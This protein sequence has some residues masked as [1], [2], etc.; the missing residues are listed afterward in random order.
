MEVGLVLP[1]AGSA[2]SAD[3]IAQVATHAERIGLGSVW[4]FERQ[5]NPTGGVQVSGQTMQ[6]P[7]YDTVYSPLEVLAFVAAR[8]SR[9]R[10]GTS[11]MVAL[12]HNPVALARSLATLDR[13]SNGRVVA[14]LGQG[15]MREEFE[16]AGVPMGRQGAGFAEFIDALRAVWGP[17]LVSFA[18]RF[19]TIASS[20]L[21]PK[22]VQAGGPP[23][24]IGANTPA[25]VQRTA[26]L[27]L[28]LLP[29]WFGREAL[30]GTIQAFRIAA[31]Q[32]GCDPAD[33]RVVVAVNEPLTDTPAGGEA[34]LT[35][36][37]EQAAEAFPRLERLGV[38]GIR[39]AMAGVPVE[40]QL[41]L[42]ERL[43]KLTGQSG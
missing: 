30:E 16:A 43:V 24:I 4:A 36:S 38:S 20:N 14:G 3:A 18:G 28:G 33:L 22:P 7:D 23:I 1:T 41:G 13:L 29:I 8:T 32:A 37:P 9:I 42:M 27:G 40:E 5:L 19:Y 17:D 11:V 34:S 26:R 10:L 6:L 12:L 15:W 39:W 2:A 31:D 35:G 21:N 25:S